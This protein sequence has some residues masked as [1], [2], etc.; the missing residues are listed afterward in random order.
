M[1]P[2]EYV[3]ADPRAVALLDRLRSLLRAADPEARPGM[4]EDVLVALRRYR[5]RDVTL[6]EIE[7]LL[8]RWETWN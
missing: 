7:L 3:A 2:D 5:D 4:R 1:D 8:A 6:D